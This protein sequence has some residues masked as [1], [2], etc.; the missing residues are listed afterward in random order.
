MLQTRIGVL[1]TGRSGIAVANAAKRRGAEVWLFDERPVVLKEVS[2]EGGIEVV[3]SW[4]GSFEQY[5]LATLVT[6]PGVPQ[7]S[8]VLQRAKQSGIGVISEI[9]FAFSIAKSKILAVTGTNGKSTTTAMLWHCLR[10]SGVD[11][12]LC[13]NIYGSGYE[14]VTLT[15]A[16]EKGTAEQFL[17]AEISSYQLEWVRNFRPVGAIIT[18]VTSDHLDRY[19]GDRELYAQTKLRIYANM[20]PGDALVLPIGFEAPPGPTVKWLSLNAVEAFNL[21]FSEDHNRLNAGAALMLIDALFKGSNVPEQARE[22]I[23][24]FRALDN[25]MEPVGVRHGISVINNT[26]CTN[27]P[28]VMA[29]SS[30]V[31]GRQ[32]LLI[33]GVSKGLDFQEL[34]EF[35]RVKGHAAYLFGRD[36][37]RIFLETGQLWPVFDTMREAFAVASTEARSGEVIMLAPGCA[38]HDQFKDFRDRGNVFK[39][40]AMEWLKN[41]TDDSK[42]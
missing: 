5:K 28:A 36:A 42:L 13:G 25:R 40:I 37:R 12:V 19:N 16:A 9:E 3:G 31:S 33:G 39:E 2:L 7:S 1:G 8:P 17:V 27:P 10:E 15:E 14:E 4:D 6:S 18:N 38:S 23:K 34:G 26:M 29:S 35:I 32:H 21:P 20:G 24:I 30:A 11:A 41:E 22:A